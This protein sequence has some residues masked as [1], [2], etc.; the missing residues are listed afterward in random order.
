MLAHQWEYKS[1]P[2]TLTDDVHWLMNEIGKSGWELVMIIPS[3]VGD[4]VG[5]MIFKKP[6]DAEPVELPSYL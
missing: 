4:I 6:I 1:T 5:T 3:P 2:Y